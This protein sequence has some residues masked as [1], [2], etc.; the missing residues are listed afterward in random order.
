M[1][2]HEEYLNKNE[3]D[4]EEK[5]GDDNDEYANESKEELKL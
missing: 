5:N 3:S 4:E 1:I 2:Q